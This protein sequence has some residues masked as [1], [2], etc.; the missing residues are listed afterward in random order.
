M[1][2]RAPGVRLLDDEDAGSPPA[3]WHPAAASFR[4]LRFRS[5][6]GLI[7]YQTDALRA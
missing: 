3:R 2:S 1:P 4:D 6:T 7:R 5:L